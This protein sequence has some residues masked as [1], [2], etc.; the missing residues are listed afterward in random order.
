MSGLFQP[1]ISLLE[2]KGEYVKAKGNLDTLRTSERGDL[3][4][5]RQDVL[6]LLLRKSQLQYHN[7]NPLKAFKEHWENGSLFRPSRRHA[8]AIYFGWSPEPQNVKLWLQSESCNQ[9]LRAAFE[10]E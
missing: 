10:S 5:L 3:C 2:F 4:A 6:N 9:R 8:T 1:E 7:E